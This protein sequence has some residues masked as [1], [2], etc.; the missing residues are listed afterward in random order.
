MIYVVRKMVVIVV[1]VM[2]AVVSNSFVCGNYLSIYLFICVSD[3]PLV[4]VIVIVIVVIF[5]GRTH[6]QKRQHKENI[7]I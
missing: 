6:T 3:P 1:V 2:V 4:I 7:Y 5:E